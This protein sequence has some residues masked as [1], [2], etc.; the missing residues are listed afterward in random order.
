MLLFENRCR[1]SDRL[2]SLDE[3][4]GCRS[5]EKIAHA[6]RTHFQKRLDFR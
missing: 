2:S 5:P 1:S 4:P 6:T 3:M